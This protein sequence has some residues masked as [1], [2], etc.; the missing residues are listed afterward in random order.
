MTSPLPLSDSE[1]LHHIGYES[2]M[3]VEVLKIGTPEQG[4]ELQTDK[5]TFGLPKEFLLNIFIE[6][7]ALH[8]RNVIEF[9]TRDNDIKMQDF[10]DIRPSQEVLRALDT[11][12]DRV[13]AQLLHMTNQRVADVLLGPVGPIGKLWHES[14]FHPLL[15]EIQRFVARVLAKP[16]LCKKLTL[17]DKNIYQQLAKDLPLASSGRPGVATGI[18]HDNAVRV[19][20]L[21]CG[22]STSSA[23]VTLFPKIP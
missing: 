6:Q 19:S 13:S 11:L 9:L 14:E 23:T 7:R 4:I 5:G 2:K 12:F 3:L 22:S 1:K 15:G 18:H 21:A 16:N 20:L 17:N 10:F 8:A